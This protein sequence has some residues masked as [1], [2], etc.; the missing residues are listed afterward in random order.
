M[1]QRLDLVAS[2]TVVRETFGE[3]VAKPARFAAFVFILDNSLGNQVKISR[4]EFLK[5]LGVNLAGVALGSFPGELTSEAFLWPSLKLDQ[6]PRSVQNILIRVPK[7]TVSEDGYLHLLN[8]NNRRLGK[9]P[10]AQ[11]EWNLERSKSVD[12]LFSEVPWGIVLHWYGDSDYFDRSVKGYLRGFNAVRSVGDYETQTSAHF[13]VGEGTPSLSLTR[14][15]NFRG[16]IQ[17][18]APSP[19]GV[20]YFSL[21]P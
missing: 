10:L 3:R 18:Q 4:R 9:I 8:F 15:D 21:P 2:L 5:L 11:T 14:E 12:E 16:I 17:T 7:T 13:L 1:S 20:P 19:N 6:L